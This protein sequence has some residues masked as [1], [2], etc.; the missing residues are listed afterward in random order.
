M[1]IEYYVWDALRVK[2]GFQCFA[3]FKIIILQGID[4][5]LANK[6]SV[7]SGGLLRENSFKARRASM[8]FGWILFHKTKGR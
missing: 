5:K 1:L 2:D 8:R 6:C 7:K 3:Y 4:L